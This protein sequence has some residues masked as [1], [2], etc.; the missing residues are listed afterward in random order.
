[1]ICALKDVL[2]KRGFSW[3]PSVRFAL[4][5]NYVGDEHEG[6]IVIMLAN[7]YSTQAWTI[8]CDSKEYEPPSVAQDPWHCLRSGSA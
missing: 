3:A 5:F 7:F 6:S 4:E 8:T 1:M 2:N